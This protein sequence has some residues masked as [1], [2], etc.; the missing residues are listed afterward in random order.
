MKYIVF[1]SKKFARAF[2]VIFPDILVHAD[3]ADTIEMHMRCHHN[4]DIEVVSAGEL[5]LFGQEINCSG[6][7]ETLGIKSREETDDDLISGFNY[8]HGAIDPSLDDE[9]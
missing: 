5:N 6:H 3:V 4:T 1:R 2:P 9:I 8:H 7:S